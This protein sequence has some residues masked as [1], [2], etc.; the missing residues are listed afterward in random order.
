MRAYEVP[1]WSRESHRE[2][3]FPVSEGQPSRCTVSYP[4][5]QMFSEACKRNYWLCSL[6]AV[7]APVSYLTFGASIFSSVEWE[8]SQVAILIKW[9]NPLKRLSPEQHLRAP[10][11]E[12]NE[13][14]SLTFKHLPAEVFTDQQQ[15][16][17]PN[18]ATYFIGWGMTSKQKWSSNNHRTETAT[19]SLAQDSASAA[20]VKT[21][22]CKAAHLGKKEQPARTCVW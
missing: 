10:L 13:I 7:W 20:R 2:G 19:G 9:D 12:S 8:W 5:R 16:T 15:T 3:T 22:C 4:Q 6:L 11:G 1:Q 18:H 17:P 14:I 21:G